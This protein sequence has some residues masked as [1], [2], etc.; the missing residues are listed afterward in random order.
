MYKTGEISK[1]TILIDAINS[2]ILSYE[3]KNIVNS[4]FD[5]IAVEQDE[6]YECLVYK[7]GISNKTI[8]EKSYHLIEK[9]LALSRTDLFQVYNKI[10]KDEYLTGL[11]SEDGT[12]VLEPIY[13]EIQFLATDIFVLSYKRDNE[14][15]KGI[16][17]RE[18]GMIVGLT[19]A[20]SIVMH[21]TLPVA[22][23]WLRDG[24]F[25]LMDNQGNKFGVDEFSRHFN[26]SYV[27]NVI[28]VDLGYKTEFITTQLTPVTNRTVLSK[29]EDATWIDM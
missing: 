10:S 18:Q 11:I 17:K 5:A 13:S 7:L 16:F 12:E 14:T 21:P 20:V 2:R 15:Y 23:I 6:K 25:K 24:S 28:K 9:P 29:L 26:C 3:V 22:M 8:S 1:Y 27:G 19:D 4:I